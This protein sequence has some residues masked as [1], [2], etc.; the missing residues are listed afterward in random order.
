M[1]IRWPC[2][3]VTTLCCVWPIASHGAGGWYLLIPPRSEYNERAE[4]LSAY[5]ILDS[6]PL[7]EWRQEGA[8]D[9]ASEC[10]ASR[11]SL[12]MIEQRIHVKAAEEY[13]KVL[14]AA[15]DSVVLKT[16]RWVSETSNANEWAFR[17]SRCIRS[18]DSRLK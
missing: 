18:D 13:I 17:A 14:G 9:S 10:E 11:N 8:Y 5:K 1:N 2:I 15:K 7:S 12:L 3:V 6:K 16:Q 4:Y